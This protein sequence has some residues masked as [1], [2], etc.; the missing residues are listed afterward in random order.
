MAPKI[1]A[2]PAILENMLVDG[3]MADFQDS[4]DGKF[5]GYLLGAPVATQQHLYGLPVIRSK[6]AA[7]TGPRTTPPCH[8]RGMIGTIPAVGRIAV[9]LQ[10][11]R[12]G[13]A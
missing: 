6:T 7:T 12:D 8:A 11:P 3:L 9:A 1:P 13:G 10:F 2:G 4:G 5:S